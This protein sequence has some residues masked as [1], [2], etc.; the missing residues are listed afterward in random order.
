MPFLLHIDTALEK[1]SIMLSRNGQ[2]IAI[3][4]NSSQKDHAS[5]LHPS[6]LDLLKNNEF[7]LDDLD[8]IAVTIGPGSYTGLR[9]GLATAKGLCFALNKPLIAINTLDLMASGAVSVQTE[10]ICPMIDARRME[11]YTAIYDKDLQY[12]L[13]PTSIILDPSSFEKKLAAHTISFFGNGSGK[14]SSICKNYNASF[15]DITTN[16]DNMITM[17]EKSMENNVFADLQTIEPLYIKNFNSG[18]KEPPVKS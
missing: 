7:S 17:A 2:R 15:P 11:V 4:E 12:L 14:F 1:A 8:A 9:V 16:M 6:I 13:K 10:L 3:A 5:W 18:E